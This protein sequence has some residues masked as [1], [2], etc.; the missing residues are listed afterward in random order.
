MI[1]KIFSLFRNI[2]DSFGRIKKIGNGKN[3]VYTMGKVASSSV[4]ECLD[5][6]I[7]IHNLDGQLPSRNFSAIFTPYI[8]RYLFEAIRWKIFNY[9]IA[10]KIKNLLNHNQKIRIFTSVRDPI[11]RNLSAYFQNI[12]ESHIKDLSDKELFA[13]FM[14]YSNHLLPLYW[15]E[16]EFKQ[17]LGISV[18]DYEFNKDKGFICFENENYE[19]MIVQTERLDSLSSEIGSFFKSHDPDFLSSTH[20]KENIGNNKWYASYYKR[21]KKIAYYDESFLNLV[22][23]SKYSKHFFSHDQIREFR[24]QWSKTTKS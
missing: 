16:S 7:Q 23:E 3:V 14:A 19:I 18:Y 15:F 21:L 10:K 5:E 11:A 4:Y 2:K 6:G 13:H 22:Y 9:F 12:D 1:N 24:R 8:T 17:N 20:A